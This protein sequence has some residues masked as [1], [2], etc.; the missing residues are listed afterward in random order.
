MV[1]ALPAA[2]AAVPMPCI[3]CPKLSVSSLVFK[4]V[5]P[6]FNAVPVKVIKVPVKAIFAFAAFCADFALFSLADEAS[7]VPPY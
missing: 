7:T 2:D 4:A 5:E 3:A 6:Q 1:I